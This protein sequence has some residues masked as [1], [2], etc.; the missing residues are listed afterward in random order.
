MPPDFRFFFPL[1]K[2]V[3]ARHSGRKTKTKPFDGVFCLITKI[4][5]HEKG[6]GKDLKK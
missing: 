4:N 5:T 1:Q 6:N 3:S 2:N